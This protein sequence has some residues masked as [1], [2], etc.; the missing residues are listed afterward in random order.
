MPKVKPFY[1]VRPQEKYTKQISS[2]PYDVI[3]EKEARD[4]YK[5]NPLTYFRIIRAEVNFPE[6]TNPYSEQVYLKGKELIHEY[7]EKEL[8]IQEKEPCFY[9]YSQKMGDFSQIGLVSLVSVDDYDQDKIKKHELTRVDK[10]KDRFELV[11]KSQAHSEPV[12]LAFRAEEQINEII[13]S[14]IKKNKPI[15]DFKSEDGIENVLWKMSDKEILKK[16][17]NL[18]ANN[19]DCLYIA[20]GHH[21]AKASSLTGSY[22]RKNNPDN[23]KPENYDHFLAVLFP[24][25]QLRI[26]PY[27]RVAKMS[28][29]MDD[30]ISKASEYFDI[31][32]T[33]VKDVENKGE[34]IAYASGKAYLFKFKGQL[35]EEVDKNLDVAILQNYIL[36]PILGITN[37]RED[38]NIDFVGGVRGN[39][40]LKNLVDSK[41][42]DIAFIMHPTSIDALFNISDAGKIMPPKSTWFEPKLKSGLFLHL[43]E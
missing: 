12:F 27:N 8:F 43:I 25:N 39:D 13:F 40:Y 37:P 41:E 5:K 35:P 31:I 17:E 18:F 34:F 4:E 21:R 24:S 14:Y 19:V 1:A 6:G 30:F 15:Y 16:L 26:L 29:T 20:D 28:I 22:F 10:E 3:S 32:E 11:S 33:K 36:S 23:L 9:I 42:F 7:I 38:K 2:F